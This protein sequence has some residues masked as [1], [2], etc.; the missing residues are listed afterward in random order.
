M[1]IADLMKIT[2]E[3]ILLMEPEQ[4]TQ[5]SN[6]IS[7]VKYN[8]LHF[9]KP[10]QYQ[11]PFFKAGSTYNF[12]LLSA[13]NRVGKTYCASY[14]MAMHLT[15][16]YPVWWNGRRIEGSNRIYWCVGINLQLVKDLQQKA[17]LGTNNI[18][19]S[20]EVGL[21]SI[22]K[23]CIILEGMEK[24]GARVDSIRIKHKDGGTNEL[25]FKG[26]LD[27]DK[28]QG[29]KCAGI[30]IDEESPYSTII[31]S[32]CVARITNGIEAGVNGFI[33]FTATPE[34][35]ETPIYTQYR[36]DKSGYMYFQNVTWDDVPEEFTPEVKEQMLAGLADWEIEL[37]SKGLPAVGRG[38]VFPFSEEQIKFTPE[39]YTPLPHHQVIAG[40]DWG[41]TSDPTV[42]CIAI[43]D[44]DH[45]KYYVWDMFYLD[46]AEGDLQARS[47]SRLHE[48]LSNSPYSG[49]PIV[50]PHDSSMKS[51]NPEGKG[52]ILEKLGSNVLYDPFHNP[53][54]TVLR[55]GKFGTGKVYNSVETGLAEFRHMFSEER[56]KIRSDLETWFREK[57]SYKYTFNE[58][59]RETKP[60]DKNNHCI[61]ASR[62]AVLS[63]MGNRGCNWSD[64]GDVNYSKLNSYQAIQFAY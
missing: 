22:P 62:Y 16:L 55:S 46:G 57:R 39:D 33:M 43:H 31:H 38:A 4:R 11:I 10:Y 9:F 8:K 29:A 21:G 2:P 26:S 3:Q 52:K 44:T 17:L 51:N 19:V 36:D 59:T 5:L 56:L 53:P 30:W 27:Q 63:L 40:V 6:F 60:I 12:R 20:Q 37:R 54:D 32:Q 48:V 58:A 34:Q 25:R 24:D 23:D 13:G 35:G 1:D 49:V 7:Y 45:D 64:V 28:L 61:D 41:T 42:L 15:G 14:E 47:P 18:T 50:V